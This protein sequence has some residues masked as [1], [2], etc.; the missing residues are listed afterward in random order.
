[1]VDVGKVVKKAW[2]YPL[3]L[4]VFFSFF[5]VQLILLFAGLGLFGFASVEVS[6]V[7]TVLFQA[8]GF[9]VVV[10]L[11]D[12][13]LLAVFIKDSFNHSKSKKYKPFD[14]VMGTAKARFLTLL[15]NALVLTIIFLG[16]V[17]GF[18][19]MAIPAFLVSPVFGIVVMCIGMLLSFVFLFF[20]FLSPFFVVIDNKSVI[21]A[22]KES[23]K[24]ISKNKLNTFIFLVVVIIIFY[25][26]EIVSSLP[27]FI[28]VI[29]DESMAFIPYL[30]F[31]VLIKTYARLFLI[32]SGTNFFKAVKK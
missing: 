28:A 18:L 16:I 24:I 17:W 27:L 2:S 3:N 21:N 20:T 23:K 31:S 8:F 7:F 11:V 1:M 26:L 22:L 14:K 25:L 4:K 12:V 5:V 30:V 15:V 32:S 29:G 10:F 19:M 9:M 6:N 13:F